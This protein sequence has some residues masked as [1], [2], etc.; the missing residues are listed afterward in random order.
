ME[1]I[2]AQPQPGSRGKAIGA[3]ILVAVLAISGPLIMKWEPAADDP[4]MGYWDKLGHVA[5]ACDG[6]T[7]GVIVG[8][9]YTDAECKKWFDEDQAKEVIIVNRC[10]HR[11]LTPG[12]GGAL[13]DAVHNLGPSVVCGSTLSKEIEAGVPPTIWCQQ[14]Q[15][16]NHVGKHVISG[17]SRR[18]YDDIKACM[19]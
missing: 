14:L 10:I 19:Q 17:L 12:Q 13:V 8:H 3:Y 7:G 11:V 6:H 2:P 16:W 9:R 5:T 4:N 18:R 1:E 15:H